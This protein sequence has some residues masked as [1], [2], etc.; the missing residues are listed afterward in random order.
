MFSEIDA[1]CYIMVDGDD[2]YPAEA[3]VE[4]VDKVL[5]KRVDR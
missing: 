1:Q 2:T 5:N 4:M 3:A